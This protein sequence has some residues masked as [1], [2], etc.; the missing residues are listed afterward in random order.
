MAHKQ[1]LLIA[2]VVLLLGAAGGILVNPAS[3]RGADRRIV[4]KELLSLERRMGH[5]LY[6]P[7]WLPYGGR[8]GT[9]GTMQG[10]HRI[11]QDYSDSQDRTL[12]FLA[13]ERRRAERDRYHVRLFERRAEATADINGK[14]G[15]FIT[16]TTG[17]RRLFWNETEMAIILSSCVLTDEEMVKVARSVK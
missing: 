7:T 9:T 5:H 10:E 11:L 2:P 3:T 14:R 17:E 1:W 16:G 4:D 12:V 13:Q 8:V 6:A 15:Y